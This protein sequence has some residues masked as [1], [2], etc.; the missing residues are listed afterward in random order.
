MNNSWSLLKNW[1]ISMG[2]PPLFFRWSSLILP[3]LYPFSFLI[4]LVGLVWGV[5]FAPP[6]YKQG[7][8]YRIIFIHVPSAILGQSSYLLMALFGSICLIWRVKIAGMLLRAAAP[9][10]AS[11]TLLALVSGS[12]WG[13]PTWG[14]WWIWDARL[15]STLILFFLYIGIIGLYS[16]MDNKQKGDRA[17]SLISIV[18]VIIIPIIKKSV[19]WWQTLHQPSTFS[20]TS[21]PSMTPDMY[22]PLLL[23]V[24]G[25]YFVFISMLL[26][27]L[28]MEILLRERS[29]SWAKEY[30]AKKQ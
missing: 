5:G 11:F 12:V 4:L 15:T 8:V 19:D 27:R 16:S 9:L 22:T 14:T 24:L 28:R 6:D 13:K 20:V 2:S 18:G 7:D 3:W 21:S 23:C 10:G 17:A 1:L 29:T 30:L 25:F 26:N